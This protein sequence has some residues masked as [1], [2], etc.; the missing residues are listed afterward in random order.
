MDDEMEQ[1]T[2]IIWHFEEEIREDFLAFA[3]A[4]DLTS[5]GLAWFLLRIIEDLRLDMAKCRELGFDGASAMMGKFKGC[6]AVLMKKYNLAKL[7]H[8]F[9]HRLNLVLTK[10]C[11]VKEVKIALQTLTEVYNFVHSSNVRSLRFT[12]GVKAYL[13]QARKACSPVPQQLY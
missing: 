2:I 4:Q 8:C 12:E 7:I 5:K 11:D 6:A 3:H 1:A 10:A 9:N 13:G